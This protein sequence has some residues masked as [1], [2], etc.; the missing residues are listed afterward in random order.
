MNWRFGTLINRSLC[1][2]GA[3]LSAAATAPFYVSIDLYDDFPER[4]FGQMLISF[5]RFF[6][7]VHLIDHGTNTVSFKEHIHPV[8]G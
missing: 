4:T 8:E 7:R 5:T 2:I 3:A 6:E 1:D